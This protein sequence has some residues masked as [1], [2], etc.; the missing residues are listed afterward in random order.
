MHRLAIDLT[1]N[2]FETGKYFYKANSSILKQRKIIYKFIN[3]VYPE[4]FF[5]QSF[6]TRTNV[7]ET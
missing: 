5:F 7:T 6:R 4:N 1:P 3:C 2:F